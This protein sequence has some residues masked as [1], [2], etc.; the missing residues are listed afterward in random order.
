MI[1]N[2]FQS[3]GITLHSSRLKEIKKQGQNFVI[4]YLHTRKIEVYFN[5]RRFKKKTHTI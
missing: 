2:A 3:D 1:G 4:N 5:Y